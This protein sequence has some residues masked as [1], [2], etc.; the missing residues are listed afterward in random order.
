MKTQGELVL[1][2]SSE[3][4]R[5]PFRH[6]QKEGEKK[7]KKRSHTWNINDRSSCVDGMNKIPWKW[8]IPFSPVL[9]KL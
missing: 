9:K 1:N 5:P 2:K 4:V 7:K 8:S 3:G 6:K